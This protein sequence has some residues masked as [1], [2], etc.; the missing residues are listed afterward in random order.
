[1][2]PMPTL[3]AVWLCAAIPL[4]GLLLPA[5][6]A[7]QDMPPTL[8]VVGA[9]LVSAAPDI[10]IVRAG[11]QSADATAAA[12]LS[13]NTEATTRV[14]AALKDG[15]VAARDIQTANFSVQPRYADYDSAQPDQRPR[16]VGYAV[17]NEVVFKARDLDALGGLLD[18][19]I[20]AGANQI[21]GISFTI[22]DEAA[23]ADRARQAAVEDARRKAELYAEAAGVDLL[24]VL[25]IEETVQGGP[26]PI[27]GALRMEAMAADVPIERGENEVRASVTV[28]WEITPAAE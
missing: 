24:R 23:I 4:G 26:I 21:N 5:P 13:A 20:T 16:I 27:G 6:A 28:V 8:S 1:M 18:T 9:G 14:I 11:V 2:T 7:A 22:E 17:T 10:A 25:R 12:A 15:G 19:L 3:A